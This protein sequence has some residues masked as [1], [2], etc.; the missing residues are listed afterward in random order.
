MGMRSATVW[1]LSCVHILLEGW[2][3]CPWI[4][5][6]VPLEFNFPILLAGR[7]IFF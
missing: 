7:Y 1:E 3:Y 4:F 5:S 2:I 6:A